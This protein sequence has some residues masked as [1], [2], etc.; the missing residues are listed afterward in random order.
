MPIFSAAH[1]SSRTSAWCDF[2]RKEHGPRR[3]VMGGGAFSLMLPGESVEGGGGGEGSGFAFFLDEMN[4]IVLG[5]GFLVF[6]EIAPDLVVR[7]GVYAG[8]VDDVFAGGPP[9]HRRR[10]AI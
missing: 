10:V 7:A 4:Y 2:S 6:W 3:R 8:G 9:L 5:G 1:E